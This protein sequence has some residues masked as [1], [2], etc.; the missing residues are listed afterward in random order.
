VI[1]MTTKDFER[2]LT[3]NSG[4]GLY[5]DGLKALASW[6]ATEQS[7]DEAWTLLEDAL[8]SLTAV[9]THAVQTDMASDAAGVA[10]RIRTFLGY[11]GA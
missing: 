1:K 9:A 3:E 4:D 5:S 7:A 8:T 11:R 2:S 10:L 6:R